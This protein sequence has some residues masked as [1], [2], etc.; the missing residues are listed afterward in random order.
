MRYVT[1]AAAVTCFLAAG[2]AQAQMKSAL[3]PGPT[4]TPARPRVD[5]SAPIPQVQAPL[6]SARRIKR[7]EAMKL[8]KAKKAIYVDVRPKDAYDAGHIKGAINIPLGDILTR[9]KEIP[10]NTFIVTYCA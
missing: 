2:L 5:V 10:P 8:V 9:V 4:P 7:D 6:E 1:A 3:P